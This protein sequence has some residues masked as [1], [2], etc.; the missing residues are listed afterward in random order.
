MCRHTIT[1]V[2][3]KWR[4]VDVVRLSYERVCVCVFA[5]AG[6]LIPLVG[7]ALLGAA[8][9]FVSNPILLQLG[10]ITGKRR[11]RDAQ[12]GLAAQAAA[13]EHKLN[14]I[15]ALERY[16]TEVRASESE[17]ERAR[18]ACACAWA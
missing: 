18:C 5:C 17:R 11:R 3:Y 9:A 7:V 14:E 8:A 12:D 2:T 1:T 16:M 6:L 15:A 4:Y 10:V 13:I